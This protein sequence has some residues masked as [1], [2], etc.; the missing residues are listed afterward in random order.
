M[1]DCCQDLRRELEQIKRMLQTQNQKPDTSPKS[2]SNEAFVRKAEIGGLV[3]AAV[4]GMIKTGKFEDELSA[5]LL[6]KGLSNQPKNV[7]LEAEFR[8]VKNQVLN[9]SRKI[10]KIEPQVVKNSGFLGKLMPLIT[11]VA[12]ILFVVD[13][14][15]QGKKAWDGVV[16]IVSN[17]ERLMGGKGFKDYVPPSKQADL[18]EKVI[19]R[20]R[21]L[22]AQVKTNQTKTKNLNDIAAEARSNSSKALKGLDNFGQKLK[23][24][25]DIAAEAR[26]NA[27]KG[28][29]KVTALEP[30]VKN[31][32]DVAA[33][34]RSNANKGLSRVTALE[35]KVKNLNDVATEARSNA[36]KAL[37]A[38][39]TAIQPKLKSL[40]DLVAEARSNA[41]KALSKLV[42]LNDVT[43][44][45]RS[46]ASKALIGLSNLEPRLRHLNDVAA[47]SNSNASKALTTA[48]QALQQKAQP[49]PKG[50]RG[51]AGERGPKGEKGERGPAGERGPVGATG[52]TGAM[53]APGAR[54][55]AGPQGIP[56]IPGKDGVPGKDGKPGIA[57]A[58]GKDGAPG[59][60]GKPGRNGID[61][62]DGK[63]VDAQDVAAIKQALGDINQ[64]V[65]PIAL[66]T[67]AV[68]GL[69][70]N[71]SQSVGQLPNTEAFKAGVAEGTCR[72][73][74]PGG[75]MR[76]QF[77]GLGNQIGQGN[78]LLDKINTGLNA[79]D[80]GL[81]KVIDA[82]LGP[83][84]KGGISGLLS[85]AHDLIGKT[86]DF[87]QIDRILNLLSFIGILHN[88]YFLSNSLAD[89]LFSA[90]S[91]VL[92][93]TGLDELLG[94]RKAD[95]S[96][97]DVKGIVGKFTED[98]FKKVFGVQTV[99]GIR[100]GW[101]KASRIYQAASNILWSVQSIFD[102][103]RSLLD[104]AINN[105]GK[106][107]NALRRAGVVF[108]HAYGNLVEKA[109]ARNRYHKMM[110]DVTEGAMKIQ[111]AVSSVEMVAI[112]LVSIQDQVKQLG[113]QRKEFDDSVKAFTNP[114]DKKEADSK[115]N[116]KAL[117]L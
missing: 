107:G 34:A 108:E 79:A 77:D 63:D 19:Q 47:Q 93:A 60:D 78:S 38:I 7:S 73:T 113:E 42:G 97:V 102:S 94:L 48:N 62:K 109:T 23:S 69:N 44:E 25:N 101:E 46:N 21:E 50:E 115:E 98:F 17:L 105:T 31:L 75:C 58:P 49:G 82:K 86:W 112:S 88:A 9:N 15:I 76:K 45:A 84:V 114:A 4:F 70:K 95:D 52:A 43:A 61:G 27:N 67:V 53:G 40:N 110:D 74:Q 96:P 89:T 14:V 10:N 87:L 111:D 20:I 80:F 8:A 13:V 2:Q 106:I 33:E 104:I 32:N 54:G 16:D 37:T 39:S 30:K 117:Q 56:G 55:L 12:K 83:Q 3:S 5:I 91:A 36:N 72:T 41:S 28:L 100:I 18:N 24:L 71:I 90:M 85:K 59:R 116:S 51:P 66:F 99:D 6:R 11:K 29:S 92:D 26:S 65:V 1:A 81:L 22:D 57:G 68:N 64:K 35:P 103:T